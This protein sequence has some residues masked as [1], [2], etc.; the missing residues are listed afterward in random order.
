MVVYVYGCVVSV[1]ICEWFLYLLKYLMCYLGFCC[2]HSELTVVLHGLFWKYSDIG[3]AV[4]GMCQTLQFKLVN[5][6]SSLFFLFNNCSSLTKGLEVTFPVSYDDNYSESF[7]NLH[8]ECFGRVQ[9]FLGLMAVC[10]CC[11]SGCW[12]RGSGLWQI[13]IEHLVNVLSA[14]FKTQMSYWHWSPHDCDICEREP[15]DLIN[16]SLVLPG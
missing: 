13:V 5:L 15:A 2:V 4:M 12:L 6:K 9:L 7:G 1:L 14:D 10:R 11:I 8:V 3:H 16:I